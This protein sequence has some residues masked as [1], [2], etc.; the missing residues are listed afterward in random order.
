MFKA[1][2]EGFRNDSIS[3]FIWI[4]HRIEN[5]KFHDAFYL[6]ADLRLVLLE[7]GSHIVNGAICNSKT[8]VENGRLYLLYGNIE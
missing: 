4:F 7:Y 2:I 5:F 3:I 6:N 8:R 1:Y